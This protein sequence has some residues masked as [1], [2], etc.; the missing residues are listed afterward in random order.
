[1]KSLVR[2]QPNF[3]N[4]SFMNFKLEMLDHDKPFALIIQK[5]FTIS[6]KIQYIEDPRIC[7]IKNNKKK[8]ITK[9]QN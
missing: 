7:S 9:A 5:N 3:E 6:I 2:S 1:M 4:L 8:S